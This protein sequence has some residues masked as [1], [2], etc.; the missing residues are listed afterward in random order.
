MPTDINRGTTGV[1]LPLSVATEIW[2]NMVEESAVMRAARRINLPG[3][4]VSIPV[5]TGDAAADWV[6]ESD[7]KPVARP[8]LANKTMTPYTLAV[9]VPFSNQFRRDLPALY[10]ELVRRLPSSLGQKFD[11]TVFGV[12]SAPGSNFDQLSGAP[13]LTVDATATFAD[14][15]AVVNAVAAAGGDLSA[16]IANPALHGLLLTAVDSFGR[17]FFISDPA[18]QRTVGSVF[19]APVYKTRAPMPTGAGATADIIGFAGDFSNSA[20]YGT[21]E[22]VQISLSDQATLLDGEDTINLWQ[23]NMFAVRAEVE[24][25]FRVR[26][27]NHFVKINDGSA[28]S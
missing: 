22:G 23:Q 8:T 19:G 16:W 12:G 4:G 11:S 21:V 15:V 1:A 5:V 9:I 24:I 10:N 27:V 3:N 26:D 7:A 20:V 17:Q 25:G 13:T 18:N 14:L 28:D 6:D 2:G